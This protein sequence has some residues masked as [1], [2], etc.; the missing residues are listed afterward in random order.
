MPDAP[1]RTAILQRTAGAIALCSAVVLPLIPWI[2]N[3]VAAI[4]GSAPAAVSEPVAAT[5]LV[6]VDRIGDGTIT[7]ELHVE[8][9]MVRGTERSVAR[10]TSFSGEQVDRAGATALRR[11][12]RL[13]PPVADPFG[14]IT[15][16]DVGDHCAASLDAADISAFFSQRIGRFQGADYQRALRLADGRVLWTFQ[17]AFVSGTL[18]HNV[19]MVQSGRCFTVLNSGSR[20]WLL[21]DLTS[22]MHQWQ[23]ILDGSMSADGTEVHLFVVQ[24]NETGPR[25]L[26]RNRPTAL[27]RVV[28][29]AT[30][31]TPIRVVDEAAQGEDLYG[32]SITADRHHTYLYSN[33]YQQFGYDTPSGFGECSEFVKLAR[34]PLGDLDAEREYWDGAGWSFDSTLAVPVVDLGFTWAAINPAQIS[35]DGERYLLVEKRDDW[36][37]HTIEFGVAD[38]PW[39]PFSNVSS[40]TQPLKCDGT[41]CNT[42]FAAWVPWLDSSGQNIWSI[43][44]NRWNGAETASH[45]S[46]YRPTFHTIDI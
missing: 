2:D 26:S 32:W 20:S 16:P 36:W 29:D 14:P 4:G 35:F 19:G 21:G 34:V 5:P 12:V 31:L 15:S 39:G 25:Y 38:D 28:L 3:G 45:L 46:T 11:A 13:T 6:S 7:A 37:G 23:W 27:R 8:T 10:L 18:V 41:L 40:V 44:H 30:T 1:P 9:G 43:G 33:C 42:Y 17:D 24:M 22:H